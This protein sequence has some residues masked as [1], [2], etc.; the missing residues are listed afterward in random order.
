[1]DGKGNRIHVVETGLLGPDISLFYDEELHRI[2]WTDPLKEEISSAAVDG[3]NSGLNYLP[4]VFRNMSPCSCFVIPHRH[5]FLHC[6]V[7]QK[8]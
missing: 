6:G 4:F 5:N 8:I 1:M 7:I 2:F 3:K